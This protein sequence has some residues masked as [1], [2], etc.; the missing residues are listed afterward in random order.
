[1][2]ILTVFSVANPGVNNHQADAQPLDLKYPPV[3]S[4]NAPVLP[5]N[6]N[7]GGQQGIMGGNQVI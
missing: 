3:Q 2:Y 5:G 6:S 1:M 7:Q 4:Q